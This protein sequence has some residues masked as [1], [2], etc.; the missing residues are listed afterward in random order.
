MPNVYDL[1][2]SKAIAAY[3]EVSKQYRKP[4]FGESKF[5]DRKK[6]GLKLEWVKGARKA[7]VMLMPSAFDAKVIPISREGFS[8]QSEN[9]PFFKNSLPLNETDRQ[10]LN[11][12]NESNNEAL[13]ITAS[14]VYDDETRLLENAALTREMMRMQALTTGAITIASNGQNLSYNYGVPSEN[15]KTPTVKW[16]VAASADPINDINAWK[17]DIANKTGVEVSQMLLNSVTLSYIQKANSVK[18]LAYANIANIPAMVTTARVTELIKAETGVDVYVYDKGWDND[19][20][21]TKFVADGTVV[22]MPD[23]ELGNTWFGTTPD[24]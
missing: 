17:L 13:K 14:R 8:V 6:L 7:P 22:L 24:C 3:W 1:I 12:I 16:D 15:K 11:S 5:P 21:F 20:T 9:M 23:T 18:N 2:T 10:E 19:G 4:Y